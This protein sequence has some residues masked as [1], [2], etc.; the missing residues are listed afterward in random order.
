MK[1]T[2]EEADS[3]TLEKIINFVSAALQHSDHGYNCIPTGLIVA[4]PSIASHGPFFDRLGRKIKKET[5]STYVLLTS[6]DCP[7]LKSLLKNLIKKVTSRVDDDDEDDLGG[8]KRSSRSGPKVLDFDL[9]H[10][11]EWQTRNQVEKIVV[12]IQDSEAFDANLL[13]EMVDLF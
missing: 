4:G 10:V 7:N 3:L 12:A 11:H 8:Y 6:G 2:L 13:I 1:G 9:A 5:N